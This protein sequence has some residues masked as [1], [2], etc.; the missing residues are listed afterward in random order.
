MLFDVDSQSS[1]EIL[2]RLRR[3]LG[4]SQA[5]LEAEALASE[6]RDNP[7]NFGV[8]AARHCLCSVPGQL[9]CPSLVSLPKHW[10]GAYAFGQKTDEDD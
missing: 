1:G 3:T 9:P 2:E 5:A 6:K 10:R 7:A 8:G 4:K